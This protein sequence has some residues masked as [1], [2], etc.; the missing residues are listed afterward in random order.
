M[1]I[2]R[3]YAQIQEKIKSA[4]YEGEWNPQVGSLVITS[5]TN[6]LKE[7]YDLVAQFGVLQVHQDNFELRMGE[8]VQI[9]QTLAAAVPNV[10]P[11]PPP[12]A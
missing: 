12:E 1:D 10:Q 5:A 6:G 9:L 3:K 2:V 7:A 11:P 8:I 4:E